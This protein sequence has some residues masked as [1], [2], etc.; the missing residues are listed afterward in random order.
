MGQSAFLMEL[1]G[2]QVDRIF[3]SPSFVPHGLPLSPP[4]ISSLQRKDDNGD[5]YSNVPLPLNSSL[6]SSVWMMVICSQDAHSQ[7][8]HLP[9][10]A[11]QPKRVSL[12]CYS[13]LYLIFLPSTCTSYVCVDLTCKCLHPPCL[14]CNLNNSI[15][16]SMT[17]FRR[18]VTCYHGGEWHP[19][20]KRSWLANL[21]MTRKRNTH[22]WKYIFLHVRMPYQWHFKAQQW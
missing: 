13:L 10:Q 9:V 1:N 11:E 7:V 4:L 21:Q 19:W 2:T 16:F 15:R 20:K 18:R 3:F 5:I 17:P 14:C 22:I 12:L 8:L 6:A